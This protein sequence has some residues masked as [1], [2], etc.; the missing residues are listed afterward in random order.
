MGCVQQTQ[1]AHLPLLSLPPPTAESKLL[2]AIVLLV[3]LC[4]VTGH[5]WLLT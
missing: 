1:D 5:E 4:Y 3:L 2:V